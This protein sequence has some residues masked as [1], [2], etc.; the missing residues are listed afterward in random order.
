MVM[1]IEKNN[2]KHSKAR[3]TRK[4]LPMWKKVLIFFL[5]VVLMVVSLAA[6]AYWRYVYPTGSVLPG[7]YAI[8][9]HNNGMPM[10]NFFLLKIGEKYISIDAGGDNIETETGLRRLGISAND[11]V[12]VFITHSHWD[13]IGSLSLFDNAVIYT[14]DTEDTGFPDM[15]HQIMPDGDSIEVSGMTI[16]CIY[17]PGHTKDSVC[18]LVDGKYLFVGDLFVTTNDSPFEK[19]YDSNMQLSYRK[20][21]LGI[22]GVEYVFTS[23]FGL[24]KD[25]RFFRRWF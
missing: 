23:H 15:P 2:Q 17:T 9:T 4:V 22:D 5:A 13:H 21:M 12:A 1:V 24:F 11:V 10:G 7:I 14:G 6:I 16:K 20:E 18:Y 8:R 19:R 25:I 3:N